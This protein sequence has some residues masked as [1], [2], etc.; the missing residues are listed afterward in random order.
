M[1][2]VGVSVYSDARSIIRAVDVGDRAAVGRDAVRRDAV[3]GELRVRSSDRAARRRRRCR[4]CRRRRAG[5]TRNRRSARRVVGI[6]CRA[7]LVKRLML[8][9]CWPPKKNSLFLTIGPP[10]RALEV[11]ELERAAWSACRWRR[12][13]RRSSARRTSR[14]GSRSGRC[15]GS[16]LVPLRVTTLIGGAAVA[17]ELGGEVRRLDLD[18]IDE[19]QADVVD[20]AAVRAG[21]EVGAAVDG[22]VVGVAAVAVDRLAGDAEAGRE[23]ERI[24]VGRDRAGNQRRE[25]E[26]VAAVEGEVLD[27]LRVDRARDLA[28]RAVDG[29]ADDRRDLD[30]LGQPPTAEREV[31]GDAAVGGQLESRC[32]AALRKPSSSAVTV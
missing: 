20:L 19:A 6:V 14:R 9:Y 23:R 13:R 25:L 32:A 26:V 10:M 28:G 2:A 12:A 17:A 3:A 11:V 31:G 8:R 22:Q 18:L 30:R 29:L 5:G 4:R 15:R 7:G 24:E 21:V 27:L 1:L 16:R